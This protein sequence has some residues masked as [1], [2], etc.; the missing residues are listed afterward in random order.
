MSPHL[1]PKPT[2]VTAQSHCAGD[3]WVDPGDLEQGT[4]TRKRALF[5][6]AYPWIVRQISHQ[7]PHKKILL[8]LEKHG[9]KLSPLRLTTLLEEEH[10]LRATR[11][12]QVC[13]EHCGS[14]LT[15]NTALKTP[16]END[17]NA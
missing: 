16:P 14:A 11:G 17:L 6:K 4:Q 9:L 5:R 15:T 2:H 1:S 3:D 12:D 13:C 10:A 8:E 7:V